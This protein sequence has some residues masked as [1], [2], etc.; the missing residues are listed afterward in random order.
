MDKAKRCV[1]V[2]KRSPE[3]KKTVLCE[4]NIDKKN[5]RGNTNLKKY[6][7][8]IDASTKDHR[9]EKA[10][11]HCAKKLGSLRQTKKEEA[12]KQEQWKEF[13]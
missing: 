7:E 6:M 10:S 12:K 1:Q 2:F 5:R 4:Q 9:S 13:V 3:M 11:F 8:D